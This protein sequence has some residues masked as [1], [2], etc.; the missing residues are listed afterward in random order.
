M[1]LVSNIEGPTG[2]QRLIVVKEAKICDVPLVDA[3]CVSIDL[4]AR[5]IYIE[6]PVGLLDLNDR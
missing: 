1:G 5:R 2:L 6:P 3:V 4:T